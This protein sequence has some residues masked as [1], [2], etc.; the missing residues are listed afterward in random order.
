MGPWYPSPPGFLVSSTDTGDQ[1]AKENSEQRKRERSE[2][3]KRAA[4]TPVPVMNIGTETM[5][6]TANGVGSGSLSQEFVFP[7]GEKVMVPACHALPPKVAVG[8]AAQPATVTRN[9]PTVFHVESPEVQAFLS[10]D[11]ETKKK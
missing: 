2:A 8:R 5:R 7:P 11:R 3:R 9:C 6:W 10:K 1:M 4:M